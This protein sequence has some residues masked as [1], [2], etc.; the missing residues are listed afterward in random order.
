MKKKKPNRSSRNNKESIIPAG[1]MKVTKYRNH[2]VLKATFVGTFRE[3]NNP[4][5][6]MKAV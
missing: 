3:E 1:Q 5:A 2:S 6:S 4:V